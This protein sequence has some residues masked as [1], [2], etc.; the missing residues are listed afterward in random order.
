MKDNILVLVVGIC[1]VIFTTLF[2]IFAG[3]CEDEGG[4]VMKTLYNTYEC[5]K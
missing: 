1:I 5:V 3:N 2:F 4:R